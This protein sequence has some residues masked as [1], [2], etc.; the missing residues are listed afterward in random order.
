MDNLGGVLRELDLRDN[1]IERI[2]GLEA[3]TKLEILDVSYNTIRK[4]GQSVCQPHRSS[5]R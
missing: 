3:L 4:V 5:N 2:E 1:A